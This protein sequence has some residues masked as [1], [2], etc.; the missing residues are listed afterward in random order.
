MLPWLRLNFFPDHIPFI[1]QELRRDTNLDMTV[2]QHLQDSDDV[3]ICL[4][5]VQS[6]VGSLPDGYLWLDSREGV[7]IK[8]ADEQSSQAW[9]AWKSVSKTGDESVVLAPWERNG[10]FDEASLWVQTRLREA[11]YGLKG[12]VDQVK[13]A[14]GWSSILKAETDRGT[15][16]LKADYDRP[17]KE[18]AVILKLAER[19]PR[20]APHHRIRY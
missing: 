1:R 8:W 9:R 14:W 6:V 17:P 15:V 11:G 19:W 5:E 10:W 20:N 16:Y 18:V 3:Q 13:G 7:N 4:M 2:L 12:P